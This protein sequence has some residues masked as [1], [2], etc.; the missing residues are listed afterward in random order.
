MQERPEEKTSM[1]LNLSK[2]EKMLNVSYLLLNA[3]NLQILFISMMHKQSLHELIPER[4]YSTVP[5]GCTRD[6]VKYNQ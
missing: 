5:Y 6:G 3:T 4:D 2:H 1:N